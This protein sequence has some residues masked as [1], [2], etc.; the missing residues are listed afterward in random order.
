MQPPTVE[1][2]KELQEAYSYFNES[3]FDKAL[4]DCL[5]TLQHQAGS[6]GFFRCKPFVNRDGERTDE[7]SLN[8]KYFAACTDR[9][10]VQT[11]VHEMAHQEQ[12][13]FG[14][15][16]RRGYHNREWANRMIRLGLYPSDTGEPGGAETGY[17]MSD[18]IV[19][20]GAF[21]IT[22]GRLL[23]NGFHLSWAED[24]TVA[25]N[26]VPPTS[27]AVPG[28][29]DSSNRWKYTCPRCGNNAWG[30]PLMVL[31]CGGCTVA[32]PRNVAGGDQ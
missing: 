14:K 25:G 17:S 9:G 21:D 32:M 20:G 16:G 27:P 24:E 30:K 28:L 10:V 29:V 5:I 15:P 12:F 1:A 2:Y 11:L 7:I 26:H 22:C 6:Y 31:I 4:P 19:E 23:A 3:L 18:Y 8:P 13:H